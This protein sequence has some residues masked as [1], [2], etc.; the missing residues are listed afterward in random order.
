[1]NV[2][3]EM[4]ATLAEELYVTYW[5]SVNM[6]TLHTI[7]KSCPSVILKVTE[8]QRPQ[9]SALWKLH[10]IWYDLILQPKKNSHLLFFSVFFFCFIFFSDVKTERPLIA[11]T[12]NV[13]IGMWNNKQI[14]TFHMRLCSCAV[15]PG[16]GFQTCH[17]YCYLL[18]EINLSI[19]HTEAKRPFLENIPNWCL[20]RSISLRRSSVLHNWWIFL[21]LLFL[22]AKFPWIFMLLQFLQ[23]KLT[24]QFP[25]LVIKQV[26]VRITQVHIFFDEILSVWLK[27]KSTKVYQNKYFLFQTFLLSEL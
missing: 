17:W 7:W 12:Y 13:N 27:S 9:L 6:E 3:C 24:F 26:F 11:Q 2:E 5:S 10:M 19:W 18:L 14:L 22:F 23:E 25:H 15:M 16:I 21:S 4:C 1:M 20:D 8:T